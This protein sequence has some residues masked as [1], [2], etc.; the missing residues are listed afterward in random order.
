VA[1]Y[2]MGYGAIGRGKV[3]YTEVTAQGTVYGT[4]EAAGAVAEAG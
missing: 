1:G 3:V 4:E 2:Y